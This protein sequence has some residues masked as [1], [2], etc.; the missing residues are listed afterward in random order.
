[1]APKQFA[2]PAQQYM[3]FRFNADVKSPAQPHCVSIN[4]MQEHQL[5]SPQYT[6]P[7][8]APRSYKFALYNPQ[9]IE[10]QPYS[11]PIG[12][13]DA[14]DTTPYVLEWS[15]G[16]HPKLGFHAPVEGMRAIVR[17]GVSSDAADP[18]RINI[19]TNKRGMR[20]KKLDVREDD[21]ASAH[22]EPVAIQVVDGAEHRLMAWYI[23]EGSAVTSW[24]AVI[25]AYPPGLSYKDVQ[26]STQVKWKMGENDYDGCDNCWD[27]SEIAWFYNTYNGT[28]YW[29]VVDHSEAGVSA[30]GDDYSYSV[31]FTRTQS[32]TSHTFDRALAWVPDEGHYRLRYE[33]YMPGAVDMEADE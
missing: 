11:I 24:N 22:D 15:C 23:N 12:T 4:L 19:T 20:F 30:S 29:H 9:A 6:W 27:G 10:V 8:P 1:M 25:D 13:G 5:L 14:N 3:W 31:S 2:Q 21:D 17:R 28:Y 7:M 32:E 33:V 16:A 18:F 26:F